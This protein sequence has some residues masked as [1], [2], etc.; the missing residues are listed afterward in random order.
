[1]IN[2]RIKML[3]ERVLNTV[4]SLDIENAVLLTKGFQE[5]EGQPTLYR[6]H[7]HSENSVRRRPLRS[8]TEN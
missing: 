3:R 1:M 5:S 4:P 7:M 8:L 2:E 6:R